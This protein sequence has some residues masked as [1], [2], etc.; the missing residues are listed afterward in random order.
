[1][2]DKINDQ[3]NYEFYSSYIYLAM[4]AQ[5]DSMGLKIFAK[6]YYK[7]AEEEWGHGMKMLNYVIDAGA[8]VKLKA[9][10]EPKAKYASVEE[11]VT[12][13][14][15]HELKVTVRINDLVTLAQQEK[16]YAS[17]GFLQWFVN[18]QIEEVAGA[19]ELLTLVKMAGPNQLLPLEYRIAQLRG[20]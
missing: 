18:E 3:A 5:L 2:N 14:R 16:D 6:Y 13:A 10:A 20:E 17:A 19:E 8:S 15:D 12:E 7:Q 1:M 4:A 9:I 11:M